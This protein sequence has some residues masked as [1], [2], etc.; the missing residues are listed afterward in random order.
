MTIAQRATRAHATAARAAQAAADL[1]RTTTTMA[2][3][4]LARAYRR[5]L[6][7]ARSGVRTPRPAWIYAAALR[8]CLRRAGGALP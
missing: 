5:L 7:L 6:A 3:L 1:A 8:Q 2:L 4:R